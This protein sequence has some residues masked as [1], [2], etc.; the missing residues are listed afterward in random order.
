MNVVAFLPAGEILAGGREAKM[1]SREELEKAV[2]D[3]ALCDMEL[4]IFYGENWIMEEIKKASDA[5]LTNYLEE[6]GYHD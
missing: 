6:A 1:M 5:D 2:L 3:I 4:I